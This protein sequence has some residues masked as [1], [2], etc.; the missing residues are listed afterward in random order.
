MKHQGELFN[1]FIRQRYCRKCG[2]KLHTDKGQKY[3]TRHAGLCFACI[4]IFEESGHW[5]VESFL[6]N[7]PKTTPEER[8]AIDEF[9][10][11]V[12]EFLELLDSP[13]MIAFRTRNKHAPCDNKPE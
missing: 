9:E 1:G 4:R 13:Q 10:S 3:Q 2:R 6:D 5:T 7:T 11:T 12:T 8:A